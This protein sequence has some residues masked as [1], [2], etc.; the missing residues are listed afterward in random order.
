MVIKE[1]VSTTTVNEAWQNPNKQHPDAS[2]KQAQIG[3]HLKFCSQ[4]LSDIKTGLWKGKECSKCTVPLLF[5]FQDNPQFPFSPVLIILSAAVLALIY[6]SFFLHSLFIIY[7]LFIIPSSTVNFSPLLFLLSVCLSPTNDYTYLK[8]LPH[9]RN[10]FVCECVGISVS[11]FACMSSLP[12]LLH[13][14]GTREIYHSSGTRYWTGL[15]HV[16]KTA[17]RW[18]L[19][20]ALQTNP[21]PDIREVKLWVK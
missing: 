19:T 20:P 18:R 15:W 4:R 8:H 1:E 16:G 21:K 14:D 9:H 5:T 11:A 13:V 6:F 12:L 3:K 2:S 17:R 7:M 10:V